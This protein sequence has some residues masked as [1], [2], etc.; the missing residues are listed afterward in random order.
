MEDWTLIVG[1]GN[2]GE[3]YERTRHNAG[4]MVV[5]QLAVKLGLSWS[6]ERKFSALVTRADGERVI[7]CKPTTYMNLSGEAV[8]PLMSFYRIPR[9]RLLVV[10]DDA[11][12]SLGAVRMRPRGSSGGHHGL[13]SLNQHLGSTDYVRQKIGIGR[14]DPARREIVGHV[15][16]EF[17][18]HEAETV[19]KVLE[20]ACNQ[21]HCWLEHGIEKAMNQYNGTV[22]VP[23][24]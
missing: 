21:I 8:R 14:D 9:E 22:V 16:G 5:D 3:R 23:E 24:E 2:P 4:F 1:L 6:K 17:S 7:L 10:V 20:R 13:D 12:L 18:V 19:K 15:L 11:D